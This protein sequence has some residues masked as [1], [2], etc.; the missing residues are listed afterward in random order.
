MQQKGL[1]IFLWI[2]LTCVILFIVAK[3][4][5][6]LWFICIYNFISRV[7]TRVQIKSYMVLQVYVNPLALAV[8][9]RLIAGNGSVL[10]N[11]NS[12]RQG[13]KSNK[14]NNFTKILL[15]NTSS[16]FPPPNVLVIE[17]V[18]TKFRLYG[19]GSTDEWKCWRHGCHRYLLS[20]VQRS[21]TNCKS[22]TENQQWLQCSVDGR[23]LQWLLDWG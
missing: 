14:N 8:T 4:Y 15:C 13:I 9:V 18:K 11:P 3:F 16:F 19:V 5:V 22:S 7:K 17:K 12:R 2:V 10:G 23:L 21:T 1:L 20:K 6:A